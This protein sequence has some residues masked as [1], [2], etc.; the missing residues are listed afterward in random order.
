MVSGFSA[1]AGLLCLTVFSLP[2]SAQTVIG[3]TVPDSSAVLN[4][5]STS[6]GVL[7]P[8]MTTAQR[9]SIANPAEGL[10]M[11]NATTKC[12]EINLGD[13]AFPMWMAI[14]CA[15][16]TPSGPVAPTTSSWAMVSATDTLLFMDHNLSSA[17]TAADPFTPSWE[18]IGGYWQWGRKGPD[19]TQ[20]LDTNTASF[21]HGPTGSGGGDANDAAIGGWDQ[22]E[23]PDGAW[24]DASKTAEDPC[25]AG[26][27]VP[28]KGQ[29]DAVV[30]HNTLTDVGTWSD[31]A[32][33]YSSGKSIGPKLFLPAAGYRVYTDGTLVGRGDGGGYWS[34][35]EQDSFNAWYLVFGSGGAFT[36]NSYRS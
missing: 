23:A 35:A 31:S 3:G 36:T 14:K 2:A 21:A 25:P 17:N 7:F 1:L 4:I 33:N 15:G 16:S 18:I 30:A 10:M 20:W 9:D 13:P 19:P 8:R 28:T 22:S 24:A 11:Y 26:F 32:T 27:R 29:W 34:S 12:L 6:S 5:Q